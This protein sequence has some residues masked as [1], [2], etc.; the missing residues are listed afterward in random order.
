METQ[1]KVPSSF[2]SLVKLKHFD[3]LRKVVFNLGTAKFISN[4]AA[5]PRGTE[6]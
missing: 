5:S 2:E 4:I 1:G 3:A 6:L